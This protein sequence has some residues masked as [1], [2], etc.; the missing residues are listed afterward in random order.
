MGAK[1][2]KGGLRADNAITKLE[3]DTLLL[4][5]RSHF[6]CVSLK[7]LQKWDK[8]ISYFGSNVY[9]YAILRIW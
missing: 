7:M 8:I 9:A 6:V 4:L 5:F 3:L 1:T 2:L